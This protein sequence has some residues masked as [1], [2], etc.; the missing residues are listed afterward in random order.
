MC[1]ATASA[2]ADGAAAMAAAMAA[3]PTDPS[4]PRAGSGAA[5]AG[6]STEG[7]AQSSWRAASGREGGSE[8]YQ[9]G[10]LSRS[11]L[12]WLTKERE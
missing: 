12:R 2:T 11:A 8:S 4:L 10:D 5:A 3:P 6:A 7:A 9:F 1:S